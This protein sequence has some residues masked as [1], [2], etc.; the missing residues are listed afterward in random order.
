M[1]HGGD[2]QMKESEPTQR[3]FLT[4][5]PVT[6]DKSASKESMNMGFFLPT[7]IAN[8]WSIQE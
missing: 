6:L 8:A 3:P 7:M 4:K 1:P 5:I 2:H